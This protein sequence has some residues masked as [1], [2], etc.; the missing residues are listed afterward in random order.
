MF[1]FWK[2]TSY[3]ILPLL[4]GYLGLHLSTNAEI[5]S[6]KWIYRI[7][8]S[9]LLLLS[10]CFAIVTERKADRD[11]KRELANA[12]FK[13]QDLKKAD[14]ALQQGN[15]ELQR[16]NSYMNGK[17]DTMAT[18]LGSI[19]KHGTNTSDVAKALAASARLQPIFPASKTAEDR[20]QEAKDAIANVYGEGERLRA[21][22]QRDGIKSHDVSDQKPFDTWISDANQVIVAYIDPRQADWLNMQYPA[23]NGSLSKFCWNFIMKVN[24]FENVVK[25]A[26]D[27]SQQH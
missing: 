15:L 20:E 23:G 21:V 10:V 24:D 2:I 4:I 27:R 19:A 22:C 13:Y 7:G 25:Q 3:T 5:G 12:E 16:N 14:D 1:L 11:H 18:V 9:L 8:C 6:R 17:F 26:R